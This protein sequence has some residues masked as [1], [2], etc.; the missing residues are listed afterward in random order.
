MTTHTNPAGAGR[1]AQR[2]VHARTGF[3]VHLFL[4][5]IAN[6]V[7]AWKNLSTAPENP[8]FLWPLVIWGALL[9]IHFVSDYVPAD[10]S[11]AEWAPEPPVAGRPAARLHG[12]RRPGAR[13]PRLATHGRERR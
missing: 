2:R 4:Y 6:A 12:I 9:A 10:A 7:L 13:P 11:P 5:V 3:Y 1:A 8:W